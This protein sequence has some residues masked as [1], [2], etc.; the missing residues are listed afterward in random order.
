M[1]STTSPTPQPPQI[2]CTPREVESHLA[3]GELR[4]L[5]RSTYIPADPDVPDFTT[6]RTTRETLL[7]A[8]RNERLDGVVALET[9]ALLHKG[10]TLYEPAT[11]HL[12]VSW[13]AAGLKRGSRR[14]PPNRPTSRELGPRDH[15]RALGTRPFVRHRYDLADS[16]VVDLDGLRVTSLERTAE[17]CARFLPP[18]RALAVVDS[19]FAIA[20]GAGER[21]WDRRDEI[22]AR[23]ARFRQALLTRLDARP[24]ERGVRRARA[25]VMAATPWSQSVW[26]TEARRLCLIGGI[27]PPEPQMPVRT[28]AGTFYADLGWWI[29]RLVLEIDGLIKYLEDADAVL[30]A[31]CW[32]QAAMEGAGIHVERTTPAE[33]AD[34]EAF[35]ARLRRILPLT[36]CEEKPVAALRTRSESRRQQGAQW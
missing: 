27:A 34:G 29:V 28:A 35:L 2:Q 24:R 5:R 1:S 6:H 14:R 10:R 15:R 26:E 17:D 12:V 16:D 23:A 9:A 21:P 7:R 33:V 30:A 36:L 20:A 11:V 19:L 13:N 8:V 4:R 32:R 22:N 25:V 18:D 3:T 31:Q